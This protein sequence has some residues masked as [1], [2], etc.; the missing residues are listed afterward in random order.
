MLVL[1]AASLMLA[2][3]AGGF[4]LDRFGTDRSLTTGSIGG[5]V[6]AP[7]GRLSDEAAIRST[8]AAWMPGEVPPE[9]VPWV[10][11]NTGS[12]GAISRVAD[13][14]GEGRLCRAFQVSRESFDGVALYDGKAC[15][16]EG[17]AWSVVSLV[18]R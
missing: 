14:A 18:P 12:T 5:E 10:N 8:I 4:D 7:D 3:C 11:S 1:V 13:S 2:G 16:E 15:S 6:R 9:T 17:R